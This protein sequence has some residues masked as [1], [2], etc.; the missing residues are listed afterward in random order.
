MATSLFSS[1]RSSLKNLWNT[2]PLRVWMVHQHGWA[3]PSGA[4][5]AGSCAH[6]AVEDDMSQ[7]IESR[8]DVPEKEFLGV[9]EERF[10]ENK[11][12]VTGQ[13][14]D[15]RGEDRGGIKTAFLGSKITSSRHGKTRGRTGLLSTFHSEALPLYQPDATELALEVSLPSLIGFGIDQRSLTITGTLDFVGQVVVV[16]GKKTKGVIGNA[17]VDWK[18]RKISKGQRQ[19]DLSDQLTLY[20]HLDR[21]RGNLRKNVKRKMQIVEAT[22]GTQSPKVTAFTTSRTEGE[23]NAVLREFQEMDQTIHLLGDRPELYPKASRDAWQCSESWCGWW[24]KC[25]RGGGDYYTSKK[26]RGA[27]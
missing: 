5:Y 14:P 26:K 2:C 15:W 24:K 8:E 1:Y 21:K 10:A 16:P 17:V 25:P 11:D 18:F 20:D 19:A 4:M 12:S 13:R 23:R 6:E 22:F 9:F 3:R 27:K 7:K